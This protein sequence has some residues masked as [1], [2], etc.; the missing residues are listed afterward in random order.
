MSRHRIATRMIARF[1]ALRLGCSRAVA[2]AATLLLAVPGPLAAAE[3]PWVKSEHARLRLIAERGADGVI[4][5]G[6][7]MRLDPDWKTYWRYP[8]DAGIPPRFDFSGSVNVRDVAVSW[9]A[10]HRFG[11][12]DSGISIGY[13]TQVV[14][15]L[16][17]RQTVPGAATS[18]VLAF[19]FAVCGN[20]CI[21]ATAML[22][23]ALPA[24]SGAAAAASSES[25]R[26]LD[27]ARRRV[28]RPVALGESGP[29]AIAALAV[30]RSRQP[31]RVAVEAVAPP[32]AELFVEGPTAAWALPVPGPG[33][34]RP[35]GRLRFEFD[36]DGAPPDAALDDAR[37]TFTLVTATAAT[38]TTT[39]LPAAP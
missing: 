4:A 15:P 14:F 33:T 2:V 20:L 29:L 35:D 31:W 17:V 6:L 9:P 38:E 24:Q 23:L 34:P 12:A 27:Q 37:L 8:G 30:D 3:S 22:Q 11:S 13:D 28:P 39:A 18:L 21:P 25:A 19:D 1:L 7:E 36:L 5:A 16:V 26:L 32:D 10:P